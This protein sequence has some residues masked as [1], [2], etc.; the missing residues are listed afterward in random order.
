MNPQIPTLE[1]AMLCSLA[2][3]FHETDRALSLLESAFFSRNP[4]LVNPGEI[5]DPWR[6]RRPFAQRLRALCAVQTTVMPLE[7][8]EIFLAPDARHASSPATSA[9]CPGY[10]WKRNSTFLGIDFTY[11]G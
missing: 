7:V 2:A 10:V 3:L 4:L 9:S 8:L 6:V 11:C 1:Q 5:T